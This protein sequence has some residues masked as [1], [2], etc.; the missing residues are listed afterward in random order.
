MH[1]AETIDSFDLN[2]RTKPCSAY[3]LRTKT[4]IFSL[5]FYP[6]MICFVHDACTKVT[7]LFLVKDQLISLQLYVKFYHI[8][9]T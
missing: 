6:K 4:Y 1:M 3:C 7:W 9:H 2:L 5:Y 8:V